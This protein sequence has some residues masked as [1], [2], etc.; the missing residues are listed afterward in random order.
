MRWLL[1]PKLPNDTPDDTQLLTSKNL[2]VET[3]Q[4]YF[5]SWGVELTINNLKNSEFE[6]IMKLV[7]ITIM[8]S[9]TSEGQSC[10]LKNGIESLKGQ[11]VIALIQTKQYDEAIHCAYHCLI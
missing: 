3:I 11:S 2:I 8:I 10:W 6:K 4:K 5:L 7:T 1:F 9:D